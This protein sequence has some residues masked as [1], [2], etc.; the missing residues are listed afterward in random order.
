MP[1][2][3]AAR[4]AVVPVSNARAEASRRT[5]PSR[6]GRRRQ[7]AR[8]GR[9]E[10][11]SGTACARCNTSCCRTRMPSSS[12]RSRRRCWMTGAGR[13]PAGR[14][15]A[16]GRGRRLASGAGRSHR[17]RAVRGA[18]LGGRRRRHR[19]DPGWQRHPQL[20]DA[21]ALPRRR[22]GRVLARAQDAE[23]APGRAAAV[24]EQTSAA[25]PGAQAARAAVRGSRPARSARATSGRRR[26]N[27]PERRPES[28]A[29]D[30]LRPARP[31]RTRPH[32]ARA[33]GVLDSERTRASARAP[34]GD[35]AAGR[36]R[37][38]SGRSCD[39]RQTH[40]IG[41]GRRRRGDRAPGPRRPA[42]RAARPRRPGELLSARRGTHAGRASGLIHHANARPGRS[43]PT[44]LGKLGSIPA[45]ASASEMTV[46]R[47]AETAPMPSQ[48][49]LTPTR[50]CRGAWR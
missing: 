26:P 9:R 5:A 2:D 44:D 45:A 41:S 13:R 1:D 50:W 36:A 7:T 19:P 39:R 18:A 16:P 38:S 49:T 35:G 33:R 31:S 29:R 43:K 23:G 11:R 14:A 28:T 10:M 42:R 21:P 48:D 20:R 15:G 8:R 37:G 47:V 24:L 30:G 22:H 25:H 32:A 12:R 40:T 34:A 17:G 6:A 46:A 3:G 27:E 4:S